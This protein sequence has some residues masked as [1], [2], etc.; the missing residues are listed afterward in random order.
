M[1]KSFN[2]NSQYVFLIDFDS[3]DSNDS[4]TKTNMD[5]EE[6]SEHIWA[7]ALSRHLHESSSNTSDS[8]GNEETANFNLVSSNRPDEAGSDSASS[9]IGDIES[10]SK[11]HPS[12]SAAAVAATDLY[13]DTIHSWTGDVSC[14]SNERDMWIV[15][16]LSSSATNRTSSAATTISFRRKLLITT[17]AVLLV[18][19]L[20]M[21]ALLIT[22]AF[23]VTSFFQFND[24]ANQGAVIGRSESGKDNNVGFLPIDI[25]EQIEADISAMT[26]SNNEN[27]IAD[28]S[29]TMSSNTT[30]PTLSPSTDTPTSTP[31]LKPTIEI[32]SMSFKSVADTFV[33]EGSEEPQGRSSKI[34]VD[35]APKKISLIRFNTEP[36]IDIGVK[37]VR[38]QLRLYSMAD[39]PF[40]GKIDLLDGCDDWRENKL[41]WTNAPTC[42]FDD[43]G[44]ASTGGFSRNTIGSFVGAIEPFHWNIADLTVAT[45]SF[46][47]SRVTLRISSEN[48]DGVMYASRQNETATPELI[49]Y[50]QRTESPTSSPTSLSP[51]SSTVAPTLTPYPT[52]LWPTFAPT[53]MDT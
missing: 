14:Q 33:E 17:V 45:D 40:G 4:N 10:S 43:M 25:Q 9:F 48:E 15:S 21:A 53:E 52:S 18:G 8:D 36:L 39:T 32:E 19:T 44:S 51:T 13:A 12:R 7:M 30:T 11:R 5:N 22:Q 37:V 29:S 38:A 16:P 50:F 1:F 49:V 41:I 46:S 42:I 23:G 31:T 2:L 20:V 34:R 28:T 47:T 3:N 35:G 6:D 27:L 24:G 26:D